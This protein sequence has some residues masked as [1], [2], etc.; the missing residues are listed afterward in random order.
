MAEN[1]YTAYG[2]VTSIMTTDLNQSNLTSNAKKITAALDN[3]TD[4]YFWDDLELVCT[5]AA[6]PSANAT[7]EVYLIPSID[8]SNYTDGSDSV[9]PPST[10]LVGIFP[11]RAV[12]S[13]QRLSIRGIQLPPG[14]FKYVVWNKTG[15]SSSGTSNTLKR[16][17][18]STETTI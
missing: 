17:S 15:V 3:S 10:S 16:R 9:D 13:V 2:S 7:L 1:Q 6:T 14:L 5:F 4:R 11:I 18:Y 12:T 8:G